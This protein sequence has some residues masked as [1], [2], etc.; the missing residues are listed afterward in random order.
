MFRRGRRSS[1][2]SGSGITGAM[3]GGGLYGVARAPISNLAAPLTNMIPGGQYADEIA[4]G[5]ISYFAAKKGSGMIRQ[6][7]LAG[8]T[9]ESAR[10]SEQ[11]TGGMLG[12]YGGSSMGAPQNGNLG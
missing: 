9:I 8:L 1:G 5:L 2:S 6:A 12:S 10:V 7:G 4:M 3:I 11:I